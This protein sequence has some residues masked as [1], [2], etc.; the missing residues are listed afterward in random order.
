LQ[1]HRVDVELASQPSGRSL[2][3]NGETFAA[4]KTLVS[5]EGYELDVYA[6]S[7]QTSAGKSYLF[8]SWS[9]GGAQRHGVTTGAQPST[10]AATFKACTIGGTPG[11]DTL[12]G[13]S[14]SDLICGLGGDDTIY[15]QGGN[16]TIEGMGGNDTARGGGGADQVRGGPNADSLYGGDGNDSLNSKDRV[17]GNDSLDG[18]TGTDTKVTDATEKSLV[19]F[20]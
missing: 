15:A 9:D 13:T 10:Y 17:N 5:W 8:G 11:N 2:Q 18:G 7:P 6:P 20:P 4:P 1:P 14:G 19:G 16:D 3:V 12:T